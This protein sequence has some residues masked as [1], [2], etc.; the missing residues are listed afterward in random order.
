MQ[1]TSKVLEE[2]CFEVGWSRCEKDLGFSCRNSSIGYDF[3]ES[4][5]ALPMRRCSRKSAPISGSEGN[6]VVN[7]SRRRGVRLGQYVMCDAAIIRLSD[8]VGSCVR[9]SQ[10]SVEV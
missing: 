6:G 9:S 2:I 10:V 8:F 4:F 1:P 3:E 7:R 5:C